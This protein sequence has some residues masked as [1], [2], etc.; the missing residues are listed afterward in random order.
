MKRTLNKA[1][2]RAGQTKLHLLKELKYLA[3][4][5]TSLVMDQRVDQ[6]LSVLNKKNEILDSLKQLQ[7]Q[8]QPYQQQEPEGPPLVK[9]FGP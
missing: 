8:L 7:L 3:I 9:S 1:T 2:Y 6:L 4:E 5:Q